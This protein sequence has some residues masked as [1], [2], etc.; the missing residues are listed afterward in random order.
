MFVCQETGGQTGDLGV[1]T[2]ARPVKLNRKRAVTSCGQ[3]TAAL[4]AGL[5]TT[6]MR[7]SLGMARSL[8]KCG[9]LP[10][11]WDRAKMWA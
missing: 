7:L 8:R 9:H 5:P 2:G 6:F 4:P 3:R 10:R 11:S 1:V